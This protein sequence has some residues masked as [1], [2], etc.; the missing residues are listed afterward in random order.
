M[1]GNY[2]HPLGISASRN[3]WH[4]CRKTMSN[5]KIHHG[6]HDVPFP[7]A[8]IKYDWFYMAR[9]QHLSNARESP[10]HISL[11]FLC[12][13]E[14]FHCSGHVAMMR[15]AFV[16]DPSVAAFTTPEQHG[17]WVKTTSGI[18][19][20]A[21]AFVL[22]LLFDRA[23]KHSLL[24]SSLSLSLSFFGSSKWPKWEREPLYYSGLW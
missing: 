17:I 24:F 22:M 20:G 10:P 2:H 16:C 18:E 13:D 11:M 8:H 6:Q 19:P 14:A 7:P 4:F 23:P 21:I 12:A 1:E 3:N 9:W 15:R 5:R